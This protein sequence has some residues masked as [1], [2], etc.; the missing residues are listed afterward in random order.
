MQYLAISCT[1]LSLSL[2]L[3]LHRHLDTTFS[4]L[5][6]PTVCLTA[7]LVSILMFLSQNPVWGG[8]VLDHL[9][10]W[11]SLH[12]STLTGYL[13]RIQQLME[14]HVASSDRPRIHH[15]SI[16][17]CTCHEGKR[18]YLDKHNTSRLVK[19]FVAS[20]LIIPFGKWISNPI[21]KD[22]QSSATKHNKH[23]LARS[24]GTKA[25]SS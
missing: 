15:G 4:W 17:D 3:S 14:T 1:S 13:L 5:G 2:S 6:L 20:S 19:C 23:V 16:R 8:Q 9:W 18:K 7:R 11:R 22:H 12:L 25:F 10:L 24:E 21:R